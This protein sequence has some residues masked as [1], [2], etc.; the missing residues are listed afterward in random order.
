MPKAL[1]RSW[2][3]LRL[4]KRVM[5]AIGANATHTRHLLVWKLDKSHHTTT[6]ALIHTEVRSYE[7]RKTQPLLFCECACVNE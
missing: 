4:Q 3:E 7:A 2:A 5:A 6:R 1:Q